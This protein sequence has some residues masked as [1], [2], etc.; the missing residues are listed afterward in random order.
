MEGDRFQVAKMGESQ[1]L[2]HCDRDDVSHLAL[3]IG[4]NRLFDC[5]LVFFAILAF[6]WFAYT[7]SS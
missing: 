1:D 7:P 6:I 2:E 4:G 5:S 3:D